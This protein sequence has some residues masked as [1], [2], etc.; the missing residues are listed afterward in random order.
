[1]MSRK[2]IKAQAI[3]NLRGNYG[4]V[5]FGLL[6][7][8]LFGGICILTAK[9]LSLPSIGCFL[10]LLVMGLL[11]MGFVQII[12]KISRGQSVNMLEIFSRSDLFWKALLVTIL[13]A[14]LYLVCGVLEY[15]AYTALTS[16]IDYHNDLSLALSS[17]MIAFGVILNA[18]IITF[19]LLLT[20][21]FSQAYFIIYDNEKLPVLDIFKRS[22]EMM[23]GYKTDYIFLTLS[24]LGWAILGVFTAGILYLW[25]IPYMAVTYA[26]FYDELKRNYKEP[27]EE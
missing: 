14:V 20:I 19:V 23:D 8:A 2:E 11:F 12:L 5:L 18:A 4:I 15:V 25:L 3:K 17:F 21:C 6:I 7:L 22:L 1:M 16:F 9:V 10:W 26:K 27:I 13:F 24:F